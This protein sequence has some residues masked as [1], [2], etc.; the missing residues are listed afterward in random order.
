MHGIGYRDSAVWPIRTLAGCNEKG[1]R[2]QKS[3]KPTT[4]EFINKSQRTVQVF[5]IDYKGKPVLYHTLRPGKRVGQDTYRTHPWI[6]TTENGKCLESVVAGKGKNRLVFAGGSGGSF[7]GNSD[8]NQNADDEDN[9]DSEE[10]SGG[11]TKSR[12]L[13][14][15]W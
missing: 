13:K 12:Q 6:M 11:G 3:D 1:L 2:S 7:A 4:I 10:S 8:G 9:E 15:P 14:P 5:W